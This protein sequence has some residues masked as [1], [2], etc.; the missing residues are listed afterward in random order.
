M[1]E[2]CSKLTKETPKRRQR[3]HSDVFIVNSEQISN[4]ILVFPLLLLNKKNA[5]RADLL[6][7][8]LVFLAVFLHFG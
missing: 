4:I 1:F 7:P 6:S 5:G 8:V 3:R 2:I